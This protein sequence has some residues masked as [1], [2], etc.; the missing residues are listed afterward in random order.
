[1]LLYI[2][3]A[4]FIILYIGLSGFDS[5]ENGRRAVA[6]RLRFDSLQILGGSLFLK[7]GFLGVVL[8]EVA[9]V[10]HAFGVGHHCRVLALRCQ[11]LAAV[12]MVAVV[13]HTLSVVLS[14][15]MW[16]PC[17]FTFFLFRSSFVT[18]IGLIWRRRLVRL[19]A[20]ALGLPRVSQLS[21]CQD[22]IHLVAPQVVLEHLRTVC[23]EVKCKV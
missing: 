23:R 17:Y 20:L 21:E 12:Y 2:A 19:R 15:G 9:R 18:R 3:L 13:A 8:L 14:F 16:A 7:F 22:L 10:T 5:V 4:G 1:M 6:K 11:V